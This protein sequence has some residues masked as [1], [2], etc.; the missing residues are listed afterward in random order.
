MESMRISW[1]V[2]NSTE[3]STDIGP[4]AEQHSNYGNQRVGYTHSIL[5]DGCSGIAGSSRDADA[6]MIKDRSNDGVISPGQKGG[7][8]DNSSPGSYRMTRHSTMR[9]SVLS[10]VKDCINGDMF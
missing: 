2:Q 5:M 4:R 10:F 8:E 3:K 6:K 1:W 7:S 9:A